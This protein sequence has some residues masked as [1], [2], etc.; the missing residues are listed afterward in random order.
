MSRLQAN[1]TGQARPKREINLGGSSTSSTLRSDGM[2]LDGPLASTSGHAS[3]TPAA[4]STIGRL[5]LER[6]ARERQRLQKLAVA[7][8]ESF[9]TGRRAAANLRRTYRARFDL[10]LAQVND[11]EPP[12]PA[13]DPASQA[14]PRRTVELTRHLVHAFASGEAQD[15]RRLAAWARYIM[16]DVASSKQTKGKAITPSILAEPIRVTELASSWLTNLWLACINL[17][18]QL[19]HRPRA[20]S[21]LLFLEVLKYATDSTKWEMQL[22]SRG[23]SACAAL[24]RALLMRCSFF[25]LL[26]TFLR[27][28]GGQQGTAALRSSTSVI[29]INVF[30]SVDA[31]KQIQQSALRSLLSNW[32]SIPNL[33][34]ELPQTALK[35][36]QEAVVREIPLLEADSLPIVANALQTVDTATRAHLASNIVSLLHDQVTRFDKSQFKAYLDLLITTLSAFSAASLDAKQAV[37]TDGIQAGLARQLAGHGDGSEDDDELQDQKMELDMPGDSSLNTA[38]KTSIARLASVQHIASLQAAAA[39]YVNTTQ[40][41][42]VSLMVSLIVAWPSR[43]D[44][45]LTALLHT[46]S[47]GAGLVRETWRSSVRPSALARALSVQR[48]GLSS[49]LSALKEPSFARTWPALILLLDMYNRLLL[50]IGDDDF[51]EAGPRNPLQIED[52]VMLSALARNI[53][54]ALYWTEGQTDVR[55]MKV[56][57]TSVSYDSIRRTAT[58]FLQNIHARDS[59]RPFVPE[60]HWLMTDQFDLDS[61]VSSALTEERKLDDEEAISVPSPMRYPRRAYGPAHPSPAARHRSSFNKQASYVSPRLGVLNNIPFV[62]PFNTRAEIFRHFVENDR[63]KLGDGHWFRGARRAIIRRDHVA[64]D[65]FAHLA[66]LGKELKHRMQITFVDVFGEE[67][68]GIDGGGLTKEFL[69]SLGKEVFDTDRGLWR[70]NAK[71][72]LYPS[73]SLYARGSDQLAWFR[74]L[75]Q[76]TGKALY[77][78]ILVNTP[79]ADFF[80]AKWLGRSNFLDDLA[81]LD[82]ELYQGLVFLKNYAGNVEK[83][84]ALTFSVTDEEFGESRTIDLI[85][86]GSNVA[87]TASNRIRY[88][89]LVSHYRLNYQIREQSEAFTA[90]LFDIIEPRWLRLFNQSELRLICSGTNSEIDLEDLRRN[91]VYGRLDEGGDLVRWFWSTVKAFSQA[92]KEALLSF[93]TSCP[94]PPLLGFKELRPSFCIQAGENDPGRLPTASTCVNLLKLPAYTSPDT[95]RQKLLTAIQSKA[96]FDMS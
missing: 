72:E 77:D 8:I 63:E 58:F 87:V 19:A 10:L 17:L 96:G 91:T 3:S 21:N 6:E 33:A 59:R 84:L 24:T 86:D 67:E 12:S 7:R 49:V 4:G 9:W 53:A 55:T 26:S 28:Q 41:E 40:D 80:L 47:R 81:S 79:F 42:F 57:G 74:F 73:P 46:S 44:E 22:P 25:E 39:R 76:I 43:K 35:S 51:F 83:D 48:E 94:R 89:T 70:A 78:G 27:A 15:A 93:V 14:R 32:L 36:Q 90:G 34:Q 20:P 18:R 5:R 95:L 92:E 54:F 60:D 66:K 85:P 68:A 69:T 56:A 45:I 30:G 64:D 65:G 13:T 88:I 62:I 11:T 37:V 23:A 1:F 52:I 71:Q 2:Q 61:F 31:A 16:S 50:T 38:D 82:P 75:G 29:V